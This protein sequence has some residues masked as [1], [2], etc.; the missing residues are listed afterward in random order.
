[1]LPIKFLPPPGIIEAPEG[2]PFFISHVH[3]NAI[4]IFSKYKSNISHPIC[5]SQ[6]IKKDRSEWAC[7]DIF[8]SS[9]LRKSGSTHLWGIKRKDYEMQRFYF[10]FSRSI[11][12]CGKWRVGANPPNIYFECLLLLTDLTDL[13]GP[14]RIYK[15]A[16]PWVFKIKSKFPI[17]ATV[18]LPYTPSAHSHFPLLCA[19]PF[20]QSR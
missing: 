15:N 3:G 17:W 6:G 12:T 18:S 11:A 20:M 8:F 5:A 2:V 9:E 10:R 14:R 13:I 1:M 16:F 4:Y 19:C 7:Q